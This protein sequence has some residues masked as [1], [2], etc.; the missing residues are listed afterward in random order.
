M[1]KEIQIIK[2]FVEGKSNIVE[3]KAQFDNNKDLKKLLTMKMP[4]L[5]Y[6]K[7]YDY[8]PYKFF[9]ESYRFS[10]K[11]NTL[12]NI[13]CIQGTLSQLLDK[14]NVSYKKY[15]KYSD[16]YDMLISM[17]P[18]WL[19]VNDQSIIDKLL[20]NLP[21]GLTK[22]KQIAWGKQK[23]KEMFRYDKTYPRWIQGAEWPIKNG[24]P[25]VFSHQKKLAKDDERVLY[26][27]Y[28]PQTKEEE[29][30]QQMY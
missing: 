7:K 1:K 8:Q 10:K 28:D 16:D 11:W 23:L 25:L 19:Q 13:V 3:F 21:Q 14:E 9:A 20:T 24:Q 2:D 18:S 26:Y 30:V 29:I 17:Q 5:G 27:F 22:A 4:E 12:A 15:Q 6:L